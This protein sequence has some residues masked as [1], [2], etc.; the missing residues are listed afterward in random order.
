M[1]INELCKD[2]PPEIRPE[3]RTLAKAVKAL[4]DK[5]EEQIPVY[6]QSPLAQTLTTT[7]GEKALKVNPAAPEFRSTVRDYAQALGNLHDLIEK[8]S[9]TAKSEHNVVSMVGNSKWSLRNRT[10]QARAE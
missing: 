5:I 4:R 3:I 6:K 8:Y 1:N 10:E 7:Q 2:V 9:D